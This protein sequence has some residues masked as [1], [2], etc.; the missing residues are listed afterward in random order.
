MFFVTNK[1]AP[2]NKVVSTKVK[3]AN[4]KFW[5]DFILKEKAYKY[6]LLSRIFFAKYTVDVKSKIIKYDLDGKNLGEIQLPSVGTAR[7]FSG[8]KNDKEVYFTFTNYNSP[9]IIYSLDP[10]NNKR[11]SIGSQI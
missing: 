9:S 7:G 8:K 6:I 1:N 5:K 10:K 11:K 4:E 3:T 2:N